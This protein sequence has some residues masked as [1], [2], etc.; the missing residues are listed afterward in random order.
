MIIVA[1]GDSVIFG[2]ELQDCANGHPGSF[3]HKTFAA[4]LAGNNEYYCTAYPGIG[5][6]EIVKR[7]RA[8]LA[9]LDKCGVI[10]S[11]TWP[12]RTDELTADQHIIELQ[13]YLKERGIPYLFTC[14]DNCVRNESQRVDEIDWTHWFLF[15]AGTIPNGVTTLTPR[16]FYQWA[17]ESKYKVGPDMHP[18]ED[19]HQA[20]YKL[21]KEKFNELVKKHL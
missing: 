1:G 19:A 13:A 4:L 3:S 8:K 20:A 15:P 16:G 14:L 5:N 21:M 6:G 12:Y 9:T 7:L 18:L 2:S 10:V 11:W 17:V